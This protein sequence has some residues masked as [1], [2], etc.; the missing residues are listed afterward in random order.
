VLS[1]S[2]SPALSL[3]SG[4]DLEDQQLLVEQLEA[5]VREA[6]QPYA[7]TL[8]HLSS[9]RF[10]VVFGVPQAHEEHAHQALLTGL[11]IKQQWASWCRGVS[12]APATP[13][14]LGLGL[15]TGY[16][17]LSPAR[18][19]PTSPPT[20]VGD[21]LPLADHLAQHAGAGTLLVSAATA[22]LLRETVRLEV[23][24]SVPVPGQA[25]PLG[26]YCVTNG[27]VVPALGT[28]WEARRRSPF[29]GRQ[30]ELAALHTHLT[31]AMAGHGVVV[32]LVGVHGMGK[33]R[34][35][36]EFRHSLAGC[37]VTFLTGQ[38]QSY[39]SHT[40]YLPLLAMLR[41]WWGLL[42]G[43]SLAARTAKVRAGL[44]QAGLQPDDGAPD[45]LQVLDGPAELGPETE[46]RPQELRARTFAALHQL[47][48][49][50]SQHQPLVL[51]V[52][53][54]HWIDATSEE[55]LT[56]LVERLNGVRLLLLVTYRPGYRPPWQAASIATQL[57]LAPLTLTASRELVRAVGCE[58]PLAPAVEAQIV[59]K[60]QG[61]PFFLEEL[62]RT[63]IAQDA[64]A[65]T[66]VVPDTIQAALMARIDRLPPATKRLLQT[67]AVIGR[68]VP[69]SLLRAV[70]NLPEDAMHQHLRHLQASELLYESHLLSERVYT[71]THQLTQEVVYQSL[72]RRTRQQL[73]TRIAELLA[74]RC[75]A[76]SE[77]PPE[78]LASHYTAA[79][80]NVQALPYWI[81]AGHQAIRRAAHVEAR[82]HLSQGL[83]AL[84]TL[85]VSPERTEHEL[86]L[87]LL[88]STTRS[89]RR[90]T[91]PL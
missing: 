88:L 69:W 49:Q 86:T 23:V 22:Q 46:R 3:L 57:A 27:L 64:N 67:A 78:L 76:T 84:Q 65:P 68:D 9:D 34:L 11:A 18:D 31:H 56:T 50:S 20:L 90:R 12:I 36:A 59:A 38:C 54:L 10:R 87:Q 41:Q 35:L 62:I 42:E 79:G 75:V 7:G 13:V 16:V 14:V 63:V 19:A 26:A 33:S 74:T 5:L 73:H 25:A 60:A 52:E 39:G 91:I 2:V 48:V 4:I 58:S 47:F 61:N 21:V 37:P 82:E 32:G 44:H 66:L 29:V 8:E 24:P 81:Q 70:V 45:M 40:P 15:H 80:R 30:G 55:Y 28:R 71:F 51:A 43:D 1:G 83:T 85:P 77:L 17:V 53:N 72:L 6:M 89:K